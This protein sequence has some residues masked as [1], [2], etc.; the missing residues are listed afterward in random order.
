[1]STI[2]HH[3]G[4]FFEFSNVSD[5]PAT[6]IMTREEFDEFCRVEYGQQYMEREHPRR[7]ER[8]LATGSS[9]LDKNEDIHSAILCNR[10]GPGGRKLSLK[11]MME[12]LHAER[13]EWDA[14]N[15][16]KADASVDIRALARLAWQE[17]KRQQPELQF[18]YG[19]A[20]SGKTILDGAYDLEAMIAV[21]LAEVRKAP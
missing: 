16:R 3:E 20:D 10:A 7:M 9:S 8:A 2:C 15:P 6:L 18:G 14:K 21:V 5:T 12:M 4:W 1:M 11:K 17:L 19:E 13:K